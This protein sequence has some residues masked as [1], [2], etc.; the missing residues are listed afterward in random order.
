MRF[1]GDRMMTRIL[2]LINSAGVR[3]LVFDKD[4][5]IIEIEPRI[6]WLTRFMRK[7]AGAGQEVE[8]AFAKLMSDTDS[9]PVLLGRNF[10]EALTFRTE[11]FFRETGA[12]VMKIIPAT[13][14]I[15]KIR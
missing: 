11:K 3:S 7:D 14:E 8:K 13:Y 4:M 5:R 6:S 1:A 12:E 9:D 2:S 15:E 10:R